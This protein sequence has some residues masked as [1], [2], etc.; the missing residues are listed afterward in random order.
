MVA[1]RLEVRLDPERRRK[2]EEITQARGAPMSEVVRE[3]IDRTYEDI[4]LTE[5]LE[6]VRRISE[7]EIEEM[8][9]PETLSRQLEQTYD[10]PDLY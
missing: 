2:L 5:R 7:L 3:M 1:G 10:V 6:A 4:R 9:D 8:P